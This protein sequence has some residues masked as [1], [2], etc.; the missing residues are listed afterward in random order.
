MKITGVGKVLIASDLEKT[1][2]L[3]TNLHSKWCQWLRF[4]RYM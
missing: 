4:G 2:N 3:K 1:H